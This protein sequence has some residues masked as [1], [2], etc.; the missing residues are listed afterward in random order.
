M[1]RPNP[2]MGVEVPK[3]QIKKDNKYQFEKL[4]EKPSK[5]DF[6]TFRLKFRTGT[7]LQTIFSD[8]HHKVCDTN[9]TPTYLLI[10]ELQQ[11]FAILYL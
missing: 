9:Y 7:S 2:E 6:T 4:C 11:S 3:K 1:N 10:L 5:T 8:S